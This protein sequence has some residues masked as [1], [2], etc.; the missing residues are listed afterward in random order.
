MA[1]G[2]FDPARVFQKHAPRFTKTRLEF[3]KL[4]SEVY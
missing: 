2:V 1:T 4:L 3:G